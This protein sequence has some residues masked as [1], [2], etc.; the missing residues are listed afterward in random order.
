[1]NFN[2]E[3]MQTAI[4]EAKK[5][6]FQT[7][8]EPLAGAVI[9]KDGKMIAK[10]Y[11]SSFHADHALISLLKK[12]KSEEIKGANLYLTMEP[13]D[14]CMEKLMELA[15]K[16]IFIAQ[17]DPRPKNNKRNFTKLGCS[18]KFEN[19]SLGLMADEAKK[20]NTHFNYF[21]QN[22]RPWISI[23]QNLSLD[24]QV[25]QANGKYLKLTNQDVRNY[26][27]HERANYQAII[28]GSSTAIIDNPNLMTDVDSSHHPIRI[29]IDRRGRLLN[30]RGLNLLNNSD[31]QTWILTQNSNVE[32]LSN[33][34][35][36]KVFEM[37]TAKLSEL[38]KLLTDHG[39][40]SAY[41]EGGPTLEKSFMDDGYVNEIIDYFKPVY[42]G[43][44]GLSG[45]VPVHKLNLKD[46]NVKQIDDHVRIAGVVL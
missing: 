40:Q 19:V 7:W 25:G 16:D 1:M 37:K 23:K 34:E 44:I 30:N 24:H 2:E 32:N 17:S 14:D 45:A 27:H 36:I 26:I 12:V 33:H 9:T 11:H 10:A 6:R 18:D 3:M 13:C 38:I 28:I 31:Y 21:Y 46:L 43:N 35:N 29:I 15:I 4:N 5:G 8:T 39:I 20:L 42:F 22:N 41:V